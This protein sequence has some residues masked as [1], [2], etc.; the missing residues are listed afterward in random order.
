MGCH[1][2]TG[3][4]SS[5]FPQSVSLWCERLCRVEGRSF[6]S[7]TVI[8]LP[9]EGPWESRRKHRLETVSDHYSAAGVAG[10][11]LPLPYITVSIQCPVVWH[12]AN[13][14]CASANYSCPGLGTPRGGVP[15]S[16]PLALRQ[17]QHLPVARWQPCPVP[18]LHSPLAEATGIKKCWK[19][20]RFL[21]PP[22][23]SS[24]L[25]YAGMQSDEQKALGTC[26]MAL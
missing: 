24:S 23:F 11:C 25:I 4:C 13:A 7:Y 15:S 22:F 5:F 18:D 19:T 20:T 3:L 8:F 26:Q 2:I 17:R 10:R 9:W 14:S 6:S 12:I 1:C 16:L 21:L